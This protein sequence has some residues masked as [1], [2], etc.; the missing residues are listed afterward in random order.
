MYYVNYIFLLTSFLLLTVC[1]NNS[2][3][4]ENNKKSTSALLLTQLQSIT[5]RT[6]LPTCDNPTPGFSTLKSAGF[7]TNCGT[8]HNGTYF[9]A[10]S[11]SQ[12]KELTTP[13]NASA[14]KLFQKQSAGGSMQI[15]T[16]VAIDKAI[17][18]WIQGGSIQ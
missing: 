12:V 1:T 6:T 10:A 13:G 8:C 7:E 4:K 15:H 3:E 17:Y 5:T 14:S 9:Q 18:C 16:T 11:Y 2:A